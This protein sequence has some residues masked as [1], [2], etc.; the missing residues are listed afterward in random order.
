LNENVGSNDRAPAWQ[1]YNLANDIGE[2]E[3]VAEKNQA[4]AEELNALFTTW[5]SSM[6]PTVE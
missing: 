4:I 5:R 2:R 3:D 1:L 6:Y